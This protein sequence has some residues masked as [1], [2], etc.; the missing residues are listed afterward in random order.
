MTNNFHIDMPATVNVNGKTK[1]DRQLSVAVNATTEARQAL[2]NSKGKLGAAVRNGFAA[3]GLVRCAEAAS[4]G[5]YRP[6][7]EYFAARMGQPFVIST[8]AS[9]DALPDMFEA[10]VLRA[11]MAKNGGYAVN[12]KGE[13]V[14]T[15]AHKAALELKADAELLIAEKERFY[16][17]RL[18][19]QTEQ[20]ATE[21]TVAAKRGS[22]K[23][24]RAAQ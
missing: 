1:V 21:A 9:F 7:A 17:A 14:M 12:K 23:E 2:I 19:E 13:T 18:A 16:A 11:K 6:T 20:P 24:E 3:A 15:A 10:M 8:R 22:R 4:K 5:N